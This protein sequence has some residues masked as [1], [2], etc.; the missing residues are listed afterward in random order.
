[1][2]QPVIDLF[3]LPCAGASALMY[4]RWRR[5]LPSWINLI[6]LELPGRGTRFDEPFVEQYPVLVSQL[7]TQ[8]LHDAKRPWAIFG[9]SMGALLAFG[10]S[11]RLHLM[12]AP[13]PAMLFLSACPAPSCLNSERFPDTSDDAALIADLRQQGGTPQEVFDSPEL[14]ALTLDTLRADYRV[15]QSLDYR[16]AGRLPIP[17]Q[18]FAGRHDDIAP[19]RIEA[20]RE[21]ARGSFLLDW[22]NGGHFFIREHEVRVLQLVAQQLGELMGGE[23]GAFVA[24]A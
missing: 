8:V 16:H 14:V 6:P 1:M 9:H 23:H 18:V 7:S 13:L 2:A 17:M 24:S 20:W 21:E 5:L 11:S 10:I 19:D 22:F 12:Q 4:L 15:C 3:C